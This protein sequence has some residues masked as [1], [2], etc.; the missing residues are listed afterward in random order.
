MT[1]GEFLRR[2]RFDKRMVDGSFFPTQSLEAG[3]GDLVG[4]VLFNLGGPSDAGEVE[5]F[6]YNL[7]MDPAIID[8]PLPAFLRHPMCR[9]IARKRSEGVRQEYEIIGG[10]S[11]LVEHT[12]RQAQ[13]LETRLRAELS[14]LTGAAFKVYQAMRYAPP[15]SE[16]AIA[17]MKADGVTQV[18]LLP[19]YP[20]YSKTTTGASLVYWKALQETGEAPDWPSALV[21]EYAAHPSLVRAFSE[22]IDEALERFDESVRDEVHLLFSAHGTPLYEMQKR[23]DPYCCLVHST[24]DAIIRYRKEERSFSTAFQSKVGPA[25]WLTPSTPDRLKELAGLG[26]EQVLVVPVAFVSDHVETAF[27]LDMEVRKEAEHAGIKHFEVMTGLN[28]HSLFIDALFD[29]VSIAVGTGT[30]SDDGDRDPV[31]GRLQD[32]KLTKPSRRKIQCHGCI[33]VREAACWQPDVDARPIDPTPTLIKHDTPRQAFLPRAMGQIGYSWGIIGFAFILGRAVYSLGLKVMELKGA[34][35]SLL[36]HV[37]LVLCVSLF[38]VGKGIFVL[39]KGTVTRF[40]E[41]LRGVARRPSLWTII[42]AP[43][44]GIGLVDRKISVLLRGWG[45]VIVIVGAVILVNL[46]P[47]PWKQIILAGVASALL[48]GLVS[49][50]VKGII[51]RPGGS[52][53][54]RP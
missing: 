3:S 19:L 13:L 46:A 37:V 27:E 52:Q 47:F 26:E 2:Y 21:F 48:W 40:L 54:V 32:V 5:P 14:P 53:P 41:R 15:F 1:P 36:H 28:D 23:K 29:V 11:P 39:Q 34:E 51:S 22:R 25:K 18:I 8:I 6:L 24:V 10:A 16:D 12:D 20:Q 38:T 35:L 44:V 43:L 17:S 9:Y 50:L 49:L 4:V 7:F 45:M 30:R 42:G 31:P 33:R